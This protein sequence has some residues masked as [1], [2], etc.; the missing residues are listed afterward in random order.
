VTAIDQ[1]RVYQFVLPFR[2]TVGNIVSRVTTGGGAGKLYGIG[3]YNAAG[4]LVL[5]TGALDANTVAISKTA[6]TPV[7][8]DPGPYFFA[9]TSDSTSTAL[10]AFSVT[11]GGAADAILNAGAVEKVGTAAASSAGVL[12]ASM[13]TVT[14]LSITAIP[15]VSFER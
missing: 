4:S 6:I 2:V 8:L 14:A 5:E 10:S 12:P 11:V 9:W 3:L 1:T 15:L 13:G 7:T